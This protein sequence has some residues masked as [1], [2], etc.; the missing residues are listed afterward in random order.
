MAVATEHSPGLDSS[1]K[2]NDSP[3]PSPAPLYKRIKWFNFAMLVVI[4]FWA[5]LQVPHVPLHRKTLLLSVVY[6]FMTACSLTAGYH[7]LSAHRSYTASPLLKVLL[8]SFG[9][10]AVQGSI[11]FWVREHRLHHRYT[12]TERDPY[13]IK[14]GFLHAHIL[15]VL[16]KTPHSRRSTATRADISDLTSDPI[17]VLQHKYY[18]L[19]GLGMGWLFPAAVAGFGWGD[20]YG[21]FLYAGILRS[22]FVNQATFC[23]NSLAHYLG[24]Q[25]FD[26]RRT[27]RDH[28]LTALITMGEGY[29]NFHHEFPSDYRNGIEWWHVDVT[30]WVI[31]GFELSGLARGL[32]RFRQ[33]EIELGRI[34][35]M[36]KKLNVKG[37]G[38]DWGRPLT[39]LPVMEWGEYR[40]AVVRGGKALLVVEGVVH[41]VQGFMSEHPGGELMIRS[42]LGK[43]ATTLFNGGVYDHSNAARNMLSTLRVAALRGGGEVEVLH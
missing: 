43:D 27:P 24:E 41:D 42:M 37:E 38:L 39:S 32:K 2:H 22:F 36:Y 12:D 9:A 4:P 5:F 17:V 10:G 34:Q 19:A 15:W 20:W 11:K 30:K 29:H 7:R 35:Q 8:A 13:N 33:N 31:W 26:D 1:S 23:V 3:L 6:Y 14:Q 16:V 21:G 25:P 40:D 28:A 18:F